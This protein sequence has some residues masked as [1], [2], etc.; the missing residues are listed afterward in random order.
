MSYIKLNN[1]NLTNNVSQASEQSGESFRQILSETSSSAPQSPFN[2]KPKYSQPVLLADASNFDFRKI[3]LNG[4]RLGYPEQTSRQHSDKK[5]NKPGSGKPQL[6]PSSILRG[7]GW[8]GAALLLNDVL[9]E[10]IGPAPIL[11][12]QLALGKDNDLAITI[13]GKEYKGNEAEPGTAYFTRGIG[14][15]KLDVP[16]TVTE[17]G[18]T[19]DPDILQKEY[20]KTLPENL[21][22]SNTETSATGD[23]DNKSR[24]QLKPGFAVETRTQEE[25]DL[26]GTMLAQGKSSA[27]INMAL[28]DL[29]NNNE[30]SRQ[31]AQFKP[32]PKNYEYSTVVKK[33]PRLGEEA[34]VF[35]SPKGGKN[36]HDGVL[37]GTFNER[38][39]NLNINFYSS[40][41]N[42][43]NIGTELISSAIENIGASKVKTV[44]GSLQFDNAVHERLLSKFSQT[45]LSVYQKNIAKGQSIEEA[46]WN[47]P[48]GKSM[49]KLGFNDLTVT[50][51]QDLDFRFG[52]K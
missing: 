40:S 43:R 38:T 50:S 20:G 31:T 9:H 39:G 15:E 18:I 27:E 37:S 29:R 26:V 23:D 7:A 22:G 30:Q 12:S 6:K 28:S 13:Y 34:L 47:T 5:K 35:V 45:N 51:V 2:N 1:N 14:G 19:F 8:V 49:K 48:I 41:I 44:S 42:S 21:Q 4:E 46:V 17:K 52:F 36:A 25:K 32:S 24:P 3:G 16:V 11:K 33:E 10:V